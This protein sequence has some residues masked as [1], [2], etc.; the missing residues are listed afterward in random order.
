MSNGG[1]IG[2]QPDHAARLVRAL[3]EIAQAF[4]RIADSTESRYHKDYPIKLEPTDATITRIKSPDDLARE[5]QQGTSDQSLASWLNPL[6]ALD[7]PTDIEGLDG[8]GEESIGPREREFISRGRSKKDSGG[9]N[10]EP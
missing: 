2:I 5:S 4:V 10:D 9:N 6:G 7:D 3:E 1:G 8:L